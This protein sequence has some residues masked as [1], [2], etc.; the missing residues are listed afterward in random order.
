MRAI[1]PVLLTFGPLLGC[2]SRALNLANG[3]TTSYRIVLGAGADSS[4][5][6]VAADLAGLLVKITGATFAVVSDEA[7]PTDFE[8][9][10]GH[11]NA[12]LDA[13]GLKQ[14]TRG[15]APGEYAIR[16]VGQRLVIA[17]APHRGT[18]NGIYGF[19]QDH[20][21]CRW[22]TPG[23]T[24]IPRRERLRLG[25]IDDRQK[26]AFRWRGTFWTAAYY[27]D[28][29]FRNRL[30]ESIDHTRRVENDARGGTV[31]NNAPPHFM[32]AINRDV[33]GAH[34]EYL[35]ERNGE[36]KFASNSAAQVYCLTNE[37]LA[38]HV[39]K[40]LSGVIP[41]RTGPRR[42]NIGF[43]DTAESCQ[44]SVCEPAHNELGTTGTY[45]AFVNK[46]AQRIAATHPNT[47]LDAL[48]YLHTNDPGPVK[49]HPIVRVVWAGT[50]PCTGHPFDDSN[51]AVN[52]RH[53]PLENLATWRRDATN[54][55]VWYY[56]HRVTYWLPAPGLFA[57]AQ[58][59]K[60]FRELGIDGLYMEPAAGS[61]TNRNAPTDD[62]DLAV[63]AYGDGDRNGYFTTP[64]SLEHLRA[65]IAVRLMWDADFDV[66]AGIREFCEAYYGP[67]AQKMIRY[68]T[69]VEMIDSYDETIE[70]SMAD[71][72]GVH[73]HYLW[74]ARMSSKMVEVLSELLVAALGEVAADP[75]YRRRIQMARL[76][77]DSAVLAYLPREHR[78][79]AGAFERFFGLV[80][81]L[82]IREKP[83]YF[84]PVHKRMKVGFAEY[85]AFL[86][87]E[88]EQEPPPP[89]R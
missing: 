86:L 72:P 42:V 66:A 48:A 79:W 71:D 69:A 51:C 76:T 19:L 59:M 40:W 12:R 65:Y 17:G 6:A 54:L 1:A 88:P 43:G 82:Q 23:C 46:I 24:V 7:E 30:S 44:C 53:K 11:D 52:A 29:F 3:G 56:L 34:P 47:L 22:F 32:L 2:S 10:L 68:V 4:T 13:L 37:G 26:P 74:S 70:S 58:S 61:R 75:V 84:T 35:G 67:A 18:I 73:S 21:G 25:A 16:T 89:A 27:P 55:H 36:R 83:T 77:M 50:R 41:D 49:P 80:E 8:I 31:M 85:K 78:L 62:G 33:L 9:V 20:L 45:I 5:R 38:D 57:M 81:E 63:A 60:R 64:V 87:K 39:A 15:F 14:M 28:W